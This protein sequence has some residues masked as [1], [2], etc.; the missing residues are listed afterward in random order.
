M[1][2]KMIRI[3]M[4]GALLTL[5]G[6]AGSD[7]VIDDPAID[8]IAAESAP[9]S[10]DGA[11][12]SENDMESELEEFSQNEVASN[13]PPAAAA[14]EEAAFDEFDEPATAEEP[15]A[16]VDQPTEEFV[17]EPFEAEP[18]NT[19]SGEINNRVTAINYLSN[20]SGGTIEIKTSSPATYNV[21]PNPETN[22]YIIEIQN[23]ELADSLKRPYIMKDFE[24]AFGSINAY[25]N[26]GALTSRIVVQLKVGWRTRP[27]LF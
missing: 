9:E 6:C 26:P 15:S 8:E 23:A 21:R 14:E 10:V 3:L 2:K 18:H 5:G 13:P 24:G 20:M 25:Q 7:E 19:S 27:I 12:V 4:C 11:A 17:Q 22:Q 1:T 16:A